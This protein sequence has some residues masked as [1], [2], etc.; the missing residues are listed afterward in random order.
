M[1]VEWCTHNNLVL[2]TTKT[3]ELII[4][5]RRTKTDIQSL[6]ISRNCMERV[7]EFLFLGVHIQN[8]LSW[9]M[10]N[11]NH[12]QEGTAETTLPKSAQEQPLPVVS[13][14]SIESILTYCLCVWF[15]S[16]TAGDRKALQRVVT[17]A[18]KIISC[19]L[20]SLED[21]YHSRS[22]RKA[23]KILRDRSH[24]GHFKDI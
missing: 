20:P 14:C 1:V 18:Q 5:F 15:S 17:T 22:V 3:K 12:Y 6:F 10:K 23:Q 2:K 21:Q 11:L 13:C 24:H 7:S 19:L 16:C 8:V 9:S 4:D